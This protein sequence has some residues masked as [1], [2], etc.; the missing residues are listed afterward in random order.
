M[1]KRA[2]SLAPNWADAH[3]GLAKQYAAL[4]RYAEAQ[5]ELRKAAELDIKSTGR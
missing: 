4:G 1:H 2:V 5:A 3:L